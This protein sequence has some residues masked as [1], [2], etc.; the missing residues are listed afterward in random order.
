[1]IYWPV[2]RPQ[3]PHQFRLTRDARS[4]SLYR[5]RMQLGL[6]GRPLSGKARWYPSDGKGF[7]FDDLADCDAN[8]IALMIASG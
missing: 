5:A 4:P 3:Y 1:V 7:G 2:G 8:G 6:K